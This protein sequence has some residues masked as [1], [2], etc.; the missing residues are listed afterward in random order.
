MV[1]ANSLQHHSYSNKGVIE[2]MVYFEVKNGKLTGN[3]SMHQDTYP[4][5]YE[6]KTSDEGA[7][8]AKETCDHYEGP[9]FKTLIKKKDYNANGEEIKYD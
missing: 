2:S 9:G 3:C 4:Q 1:G 7:R 6:P 8:L 5:Y